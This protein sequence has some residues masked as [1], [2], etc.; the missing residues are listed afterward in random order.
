VR[1]ESDKN[2]QKFK[3]ILIADNDNSKQKYSSSIRGR[4][5]DKNVDADLQKSFILSYYEKENK[6]KSVNYFE[7]SISD[8]NRGA[9]LLRMIIPTNDEPALTSDQIDEHFESIDSYSKKIELNPNTPIYY[10]GRSMDFMLV[11]D[12]QNAIDDL[13]KVLIMRDDFV[14]GY[15]N[16]AAIRMKQIETTMLKDNDE[17]MAEYKKT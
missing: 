6:V 16:R 9:I 13:N 5:Q 3:K 14:L 4:V 11:Q 2:I 17:E 10:F 12:F 8:F 15:F 7:K 1:K